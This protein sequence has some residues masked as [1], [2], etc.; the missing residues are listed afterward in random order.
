VVSVTNPHGRILGFLDRSRY[1]FFQ[2]APQ[3]YSLGWLDPVPDPLLLKKC[4]IAGNRTLTSGSAARNPDYWTTKAVLQTLIKLLIYSL[5]IHCVLVIDNSPAYLRE[6]ALFKFKELSR[7]SVA[8]DSFTFWAIR[9]DN[10]LL[11]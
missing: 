1:F 4:G 3:L 5:L 8:H 9:T 7:A 2:V 10:Q 11:R 6:T